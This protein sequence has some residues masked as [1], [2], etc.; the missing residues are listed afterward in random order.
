MDIENLNDFMLSI[1]AG[2]IVQRDDR[3][4][5]QW[6]TQMNAFSLCKVP[7]TQ[8]LYF[9]VMQV[10]PAMF[11]NDN[12][13]VECVSWYQAITFCNRL[14]MLSGLPEA[15][16]MNAHSEHVIWH[17]DRLGFRLPTDAEWEYACCA[18]QKSVQYDDID[19]IAWY[20]EN[21]HDTTHPVAEKK[22]NA[23]GIYDMLGNVWEWCWDLYDPEEYGSYRIFRGGGWSDDSR[24]CLATNRRRSH[25]TF[26]I[27]DLGFRI[28]R[29]HK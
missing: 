26:C 11:N 14:S 7:V 21:S 18:G 19:K 25:P 28:A 8:S 22:P 20:Y 15:Y 4:N 29:S 10:Q 23:F 13:P 27:E 2:S 9:A 12:A 17:R 16:E 24:G 3:R 6:S 1:P 5:A